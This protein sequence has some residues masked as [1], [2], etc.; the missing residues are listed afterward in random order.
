MH[1]A[2]ICV[3]YRVSFPPAQY[4][5]LRAG[6]SFF[7]DRRLPSM[8]LAIPVHATPQ[9][10]Q[11]EEHVMPPC[12]VQDYSMHPQMEQLGIQGGQFLCRD[13]RRS[14]SS[15]QSSLRS[16]DARAC[17][18]GCQA[19]NQS[20]KQSNNRSVNQS[21]NQSI[22]PSINQSINQSTSQPINQSII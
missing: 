17:F 1:N 10:I 5:D 12:D 9:G 20:I 4:G 21:I 8:R 13:P 19:I 3:S 15:Q 16:F 11:Q 18:C 6:N 22:N 2:A 14:R 7:A